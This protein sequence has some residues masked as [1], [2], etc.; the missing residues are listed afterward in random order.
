MKCKP[1]RV[2]MVE[3]RDAKDRPTGV[4]VCPECESRITLVDVGYLPS[5]T[6][7]VPVEPIRFTEA[8]LMGDPLSGAVTLSPEAKAKHAQAM[9]DSVAERVK[10][11]DLRTCAWYKCPVLFKPTA[12]TK[13]YCSEEGERKQQLLYQRQHREDKARARS[14]FVVRP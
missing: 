2:P 12:V 9:R 7:A 1:C 10:K 11:L 6:A 13:K 14:R 8:E 5:V 4:V 3:Q